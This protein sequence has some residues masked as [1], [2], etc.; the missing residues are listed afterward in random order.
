MSAQAHPITQKVSSIYFRYYKKGVWRAAK[1]KRACR[2]AAVV[3][4]EKPF[5][6]VATYLLCETRER[7]K[8][9]LQ[10]RLHS[11]HRPMQGTLAART[12]LR[13]L[14]LEFI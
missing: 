3:T 1:G 12:A 10:A 5:L 6:N 7:A 14:L 4:Q 2:E 11:A 13:S 8:L 9:G